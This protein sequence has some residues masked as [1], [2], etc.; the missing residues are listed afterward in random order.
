MIGYLS[1]N[2]GLV[3]NKIINIEKIIKWIQIIT[4]VVLTRRW[5]IV[6]I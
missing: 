6:V 2:I 1:Q 5:R 3:S 4:N